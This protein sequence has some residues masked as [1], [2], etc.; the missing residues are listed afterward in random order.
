ME[1]AYV[2]RQCGQIPFHPNAVYK[3]D[4]SKLP[5]DPLPPYQ[6]HMKE[7]GIDKAL[8]VQ[9]EPYGD[10]HTLVLDCLRRTSPDKFKATSLF[11]PKNPESPKK[12]AALVKREPRIVSPVSIA[13]RG[14][15]VYLESFAAPYVRALWKAAV[16]S[17]L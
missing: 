17:G 4:T 14:K 15:E 13:H 1:H 5:A 12:L 2:Q 8:F 3:P 10:D 9:P 11:Y 16:D 6:A 7:F